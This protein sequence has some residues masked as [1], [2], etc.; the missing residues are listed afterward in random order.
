[1][2]RKKLYIFLLGI[3]VSFISADDDEIQSIKD[4][5]K[6][7]SNI[8]MEE[9]LGNDRLFQAYHKCFLEQGPCTPDARDMKS[10]YRYSFFNAI[11]EC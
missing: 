7:F 11:L 9:I 6:K 5:L 3:L 2:N 8:N 10:K 1:M 4:F